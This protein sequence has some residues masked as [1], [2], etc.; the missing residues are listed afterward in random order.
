MTDE[1]YAQKVY[2][3]VSGDRIFSIL[4]I[5][6]LL[7]IASSSSIV[8]KNK[9]C[10]RRK[11]CMLQQKCEF[12]FEGGEIEELVSLLISLCLWI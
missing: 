3:G 12:K 4:F 2:I 7:S 5:D 9:G 8:L 1:N 10:R 6:L 11:L